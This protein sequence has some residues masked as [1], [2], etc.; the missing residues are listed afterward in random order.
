MQK[1]LP[2]GSRFPFFGENENIN[3]YCGDRKSTV[4]QT[5]ASCSSIIGYRFYLKIKFV[6][7]KMQKG[8]PSASRPPIFVETKILTTIILATKKVL[9][10]NKLGAVVV[11]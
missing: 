2:T 10:F 5:A 9:C 11:L 8:L 7:S 4:F 3:R 1:G 6:E